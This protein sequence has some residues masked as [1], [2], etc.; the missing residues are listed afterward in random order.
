MLRRRAA[1]DRVDD[2][3]EWCGGV[4]Q[5]AV[6]RHVFFG[7]M[8]AHNEI[9]FELL[10][11]ELVFCSL[12]QSPDQRVQIDFQDEDSVERVKEF[13]E[14]PRTAT[15]EGQALVLVGDQGSDFVHLPDVPVRWHVIRRLP[16]FRVSLVG[17]VGVAVSLALSRG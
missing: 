9:A 2:V 14:V 3:G 15:E 17:Q 5:D 12:L 16:R 6:L 11:A 8:Q 1:D 7:S 10:S 4:D 13:E